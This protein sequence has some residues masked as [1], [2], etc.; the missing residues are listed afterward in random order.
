MHGFFLMPSYFQQ[1]EFMKQPKFFILDVDDKT[2]GMDFNS[3]VDLP[4]H[5][6]GF[7]TFDKD[8]K[9]PEV[10]F[11][12]H[13]DDEKRIITG[14]AIA[15]NLPIKRYDEEN[16][17]HFVIFTAD[18]AK[19][20]W[21]KMMKNGY[22]HNVNEMH[23]S[24]SSLKGMT[25][26]ESFMI[27][28]KAGIYP[29]HFKDQNLKDG[30]IVVSY[31]CENDDA[32]DGCKS[33]KYQGFS[34]EGWFKKIPLKMKGEFSKT[35]KYT[36]AKLSQVNTWE[37]EVMEEEIDFG[38][39]IHSAWI[40]ED[41]TMKESGRLQSGEYIL[42]DRRKIMIDSTGTVVMIDGKTKEQMSNQ[43]PHKMSKPVTKK[44][45]LMKRLFGK[46]KFETATTVDGLVLSWEGD[47]AEGTEVKVKAATEGEADILAPEGDHTIPAGEG[48]MKVI[49]IDGNG[50]V[51]AITEVDEN[52]NSEEVE[53]AMKKII[54]DNKTA[55]KKL[56]DEHKTALAKVEADN[57]AAMSAME[58][59]FNDKIT[60]F[61][62]MLTEMAQE[63]DEMKG[64][65]SGDGKKKFNRGEEK[66]PGYRKLLKPAKS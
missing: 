8:G 50:K 61:K 47:L 35:G 32:W 26:Y 43:K 17:E 49:T 16:G 63:I 57:K 19:R 56:E 65:E 25:L 40:Q 39:V 51:T 59:M 10:N 29:E 37:I 2:E 18:S 20:I 12:M 34:I 31:F 4:A 36:M 1:R 46:E 23:E 33:G 5:M 64:D 11:K 53:Q 7:M 44:P 30:S 27:D 15:T 42:P 14:V 41:G 13:F 22:L 28:K 38:T 58:K 48:K 52:Q 21:I 3:L 6:K 54:A 24:N 45:S 62:E 60:E 66:E 55:M 9:V